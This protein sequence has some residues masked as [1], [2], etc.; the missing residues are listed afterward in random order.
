[1]PTILTLF[2]EIETEGTLAN[3]FCETNIT[4]TPK[5]GKDTLK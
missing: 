1:M 2:H 4:L 3:S 5:P